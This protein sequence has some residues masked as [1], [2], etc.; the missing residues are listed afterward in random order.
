MPSGEG[1]R[2]LAGFFARFQRLKW[3][4]DLS[5]DGWVLFTTGGLRNFAYGFVSVVLA[6]YLAA[7][8]LDVVAVGVVFTAALA[9]GAAMTLLLTA[10]AD[11]V[12]RRRVLMVGAALMA[13]AGAV[14]AVTDNPLLLI[15]AAIIGTISPSGKEV[16]PF[17]SVELAILPQTTGERN[18]TGL[19]AAYNLVAYLAG[20][21]GTLAVGVP[22]FLAW[23]RW[24]GTAHSSGATWRHR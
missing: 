4:R 9:G 19:F 10:I 1:G 18:R 24:R 21:L 23:N 16:G 22:S 11:R 13:M 5:P 6:L 15:T 8:G 17:L 20:A 7:L 12:G 14:F 2:T 3:M